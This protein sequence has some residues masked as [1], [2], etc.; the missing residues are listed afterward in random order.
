MN[1]VFKFEMIFLLFF[2]DLMK[3]LPLYLQFKEN[4]R[5]LV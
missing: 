1:I 2:F 3:H 4:V 5:G